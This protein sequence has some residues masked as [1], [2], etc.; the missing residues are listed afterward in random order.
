M[1]KINFYLLILLTISNIGWGQN[2]NSGLDYLRENSWSFDIVNE[3]PL[4]Y[5]LMPFK[6]RETDEKFKPML[7]LTKITLTASSK[8]PLG[9]STEI[10][11]FAIPSDVGYVLL[12]SSSAYLGSLREFP[13]RPTFIVMKDI[14]GDSELFCA[15]N[16]PPQD[17]S[18]LEFLSYPFVGLIVKTKGADNKL[19][20]T[21]VEKIT[22]D[23]VGVIG[24][25]PR[26]PMIPVWGRPRNN[27][28]ESVVLTSGG[29]LLRVEDTAQKEHPRRMVEIG[30][31]PPPPEAKIPTWFVDRQRWFATHFWCLG[32]GEIIDNSFSVLILY[33]DQADSWNVIV[34]K[35]NITA[36]GNINT[37]IIK[38]DQLKERIGFPIVLP[39]QKAKEGELHWAS[40][41]RTNKTLLIGSYSRE[42]GITWKTLPAIDGYFI[43]G[44]IDANGNAHLYNIVKADNINSLLESIYVLEVK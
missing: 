19:S 34:S 6:G 16:P 2:I 37:K 42:N 43:G 9:M 14:V 24:R 17:D 15:I 22:D 38:N 35:V 36:D 13:I 32:A 21:I 44:Y 11:S 5:R 26:P 4:L 33:L 1:K 29:L 31:I 8:Y 23:G 25:I 12:D 7:Q 18:N 28:N 27:K 39:M 30:K 40:I 3:Q 10:N 41:S 20:S